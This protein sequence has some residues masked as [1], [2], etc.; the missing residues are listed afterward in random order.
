MCAC[1]YIYIYVSVNSALFEALGVFSP[2]AIGKQTCSERPP[3][4]K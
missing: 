4:A 1:V 3:V 2:F